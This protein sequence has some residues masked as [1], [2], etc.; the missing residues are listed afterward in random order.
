MG[1]EGS[2][3]FNQDGSL[4][5]ILSTESDGCAPKMLATGSIP[6][7]TRLEEYS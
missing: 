4:L 7:D 6:P 2:E 1:W 5:K 3:K